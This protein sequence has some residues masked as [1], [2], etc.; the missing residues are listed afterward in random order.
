VVLPLHMALR[1]YPIPIHYEVIFKVH[2]WCLNSELDF[3]NN[4]HNHRTS[5]EE[6][7]QEKARALT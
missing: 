7:D 6:E 4:L 5:E 3:K 1:T 2:I